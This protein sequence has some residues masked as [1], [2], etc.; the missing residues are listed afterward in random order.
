MLSPKLRSLRATHADAMLAR[1][2]KCQSSVTIAAPQA[3]LREDAIGCSWALC[4]RKGN[5][6]QMGEVDTIAVGEVL[7]CYWRC[8]VRE[9]PWLLPAVMGRWLRIGEFRHDI[10]VFIARVF[11]IRLACLNHRCPATGLYACTV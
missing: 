6:M 10:L 4:D 7:G 11:S 2:R 8:G 5:A 1:V 9:L 3:L